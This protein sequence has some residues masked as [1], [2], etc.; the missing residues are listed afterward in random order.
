MTG[1]SLTDQGLFASLPPRGTAA[2]LALSDD[3][4]FAPGSRLFEEGRRADRFWVV[5]TGTVALDT[6]IPG[7]SPVVVETVGAGELVGWS[8]LV[9]PHVWRLG[10]TAATAVHARQFGAAEVLELCARDPV[11]GEA[12]ARYVAGV[13]GRRLEA[14]RT[15]L[16]DLY[17][18]HG[19]GAPR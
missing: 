3:V 19:A 14:T 16:L 7:R 17:A 15:R 18:P 8:W 2:L 5:R 11:V 9:P 1:D 12:L 4:S 6:H 13:V 10:A